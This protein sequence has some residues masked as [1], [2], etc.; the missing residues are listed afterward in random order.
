MSVD[1]G[2]MIVVADT[3]VFL[4]AALD[5]PEKGQI[6]R[7]TLGCRLVAPGAL[8]YELG[9]ALSALLKRK[10]L[11]PQQ[12]M[13]IWVELGK[14]QVEL[15]STNLAESL[16]IAA[17]L[18]IY[19]YDAY[20]LECALARAAPLLTLDRRLRD[21]ARRLGIETLELK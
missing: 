17:R 3:N 7:S 9:N 2:Q 5:E 20:V 4:A 21:N 1:L 11:Q 19:A 8:P 15:H 10:R 14:I 16:L 12:V 13:P 6:V 18:G